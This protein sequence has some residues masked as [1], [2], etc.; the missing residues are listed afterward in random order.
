[1]RTSKLLLIKNLKLPQIAPNQQGHRSLRTVG[2]WARYERST[3]QIRTAIEH[4]PDADTL[5]AMRLQS[6]QQEAQAKAAAKAAANQFYGGM[7]ALGAP[8]PMMP[9]QNGTVSF[10]VGAGSSS[11]A[12]NTGAAWV[13]LFYN[14][15]LY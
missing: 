4:C 14:A 1:M 5:E 3:D 9:L 12:G 8:P 11:S 15:M 2:Q 6:E 7:P 13:L 10:H